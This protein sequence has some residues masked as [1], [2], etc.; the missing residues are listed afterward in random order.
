MFFV[1]SPE[2]PKYPQGKRRKE[3]KDRTIYKML[4]VSPSSSELNNFYQTKVFNASFV[5]NYSC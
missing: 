4:D 3:V 1:A 2:L 5:C